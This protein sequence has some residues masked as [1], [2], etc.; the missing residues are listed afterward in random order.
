MK[1]IMNIVSIT[2]I[3]LVGGCD[4]CTLFYAFRKEEASNG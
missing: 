2:L 4:E 1:L 3:S